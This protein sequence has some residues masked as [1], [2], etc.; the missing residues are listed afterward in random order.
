[1]RLIMTELT[2]LTNYLQLEQLLLKAVP[3]SRAHDRRCD[4]ELLPTS[5]KGLWLIHSTYTHL[6]TL[7]EQLFLP[8]RCVTIYLIPCLSSYV[9]VLLVILSLP[10]LRSLVYVR[11]CLAS[12]FKRPPT[13]SHHE[14]ISLPNT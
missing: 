4:T 10:F 14:N 1:M 13:T 2:L 6:T 9:F 7:T 12:V 8:P 3:G 11:I 5:V